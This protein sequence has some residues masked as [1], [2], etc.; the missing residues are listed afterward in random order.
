LLF[1]GRTFVRFPVGLVIPGGILTVVPFTEPVLLPVVVIGPAFVVP[2]GTLMMLP[3]GSVLGLLSPGG[4]T[5]VG[6]PVEFPPGI[7]RSG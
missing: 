7:C 4:R 2:G 3:G 5:F 6:G 1:P